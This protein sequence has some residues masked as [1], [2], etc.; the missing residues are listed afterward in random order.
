MKILFLFL[1]PGYVRQY[2]SAIRQLADKGYEIVLAFNS[3]GKQASD[4]LHYVL[5]AEYPNVSF[6]VFPKR[7][8]KYLSIV[9]SIRS[10]MDQL[11][12]LDPAY[13]GAPLLK[14]RTMDKAGLTMNRMG[15]S[16]WN[17]LSRAFFPLFRNRRVR[18]S[19]HQSLMYLESL[20]PTAANVDRFISKIRPDIVLVTPMVNHASDQVE[21]V[22]SAHAARIPAGLCVAS[23]DNL[24]NKGLIRIPVEKTF[25]WNETQKNEAINMHYV[26]P[27]TVA[28]TGAQ[29]FDKWF[30]QAPST[31]YDRFIQR[32]GLQ[33][34]R[35]VLYLASS[36]FIGGS[37]ESD[38]VKRWIEAIRQDPELGD[39]GILVRPHPQNADCWA[40]I[41]LSA[42]GDVSIW[43]RAG[44][45]P[46]NPASKSDFFDSLY[47]AS[48][49]VGLNTTAQIEAGIVGTPVFCIEAPEFRGTQSGTLHFH[50]LVRLG[51]LQLS[52]SVEEH[53]VQLREMLATT[54]SEQK[55]RNLGFIRAFVRPFGEDAPAT[56]IFVE[57]VE[58][59]GTMKPKRVRRRWLGR[60][61]LGW[62][63][64][65]IAVLS[66]P[67]QNA[68][69][70]RN[71]LPRL[72]S[73][74][75]SR[76]SRWKRRL[77]GE[78]LAAN[79]F[80]SSAATRGPLDD[81][82]WQARKALKDVAKGN[83]KVIVGPWMSE[84]GFEVLYWIP[85]LRWA[86][87]E[88]GIER[89]RLVIVTRG[90]AGVWYSDFSGRCFEMFTRMGL[91]E[92]RQVQQERWD[93]A[94]GQKQ[95]FPTK[96]EL[97]FVDQI[98]RE[99]G[100]P[101]ALLIHPSLMYNTLKFYWRGN[102]PAKYLEKFTSYRPLP[103]DSL[104][105][106]DRL[107]DVLP[108]EYVAVR[109]YFRPSFPDTVENRRMIKEVIWQL[110]KKFKI[111]SL[112]TGMEFDDH[113]DFEL[114]RGEAVTFVDEFMTP[115]N[116]LAVQSAIISRARFFVG[117][118][119][120][121]SYLAPFYGKKSLAIS[122][123]P[124]HLLPAHSH[125]AQRAYRVIGGAMA[126]ISTDD[127][128]LVKE[129]FGGGVFGGS[130]KAP[131]VVGQELQD[132]ND[133]DRNVPEPQ[134]YAVGNR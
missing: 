56:P 65:A 39:I 58:E 31:D 114:G 71:A 90:G 104:K 112:N 26:R 103:L 102:A 9:R 133:D 76:I 19:A 123:H 91:E 74:A 10:T 25:V 20:T 89:D 95:T 79:K 67:K 126:C 131:A 46:V 3:I 70:L 124:E 52:S 30:E 105:I 60:L 98:R 128:D 47:F 81:A 99:I 48:A 69:R 96:F 119:G 17:R 55:Q 8:D 33:G 63:L 127:L 5:A 14:Q 61:G 53:V 122:S 36:G 6:R 35:F 64:W 21:A 15:T 78:K 88:F 115:E 54:S 1:H 50:H 12:Y 41:D 45:N 24:S 18:Q 86:C 87:K 134:T 83:T 59:L 37:Y 111:V 68:P 108:E 75:R 109:F 57:H 130:T 34:Q 129:L 66:F 2:E 49:A 38:F 27:E 42:Y 22:R 106:D 97:N 120:G 16:N 93:E 72:A 100:D 101:S 43:P 44:A 73:S 32:A 80:A 13:D 92:F 121:L 118:Y 94:R 84:V 40:D 113:L 77:T 116:N 110:S 28:V 4:Q 132:A 85:F 107:A 51:L 62:L 29:C 117:T 23:W 7:S 11:R 82:S 125:A